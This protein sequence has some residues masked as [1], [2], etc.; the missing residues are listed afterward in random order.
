MRGCYRAATER[1]KP[2]AVAK[3]IATGPG[4]RGMQMG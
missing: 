4:N 1:R 3:V 2:V